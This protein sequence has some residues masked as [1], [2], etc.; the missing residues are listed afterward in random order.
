MT[1]LR[2]GDQLIRFDR[3]TTISAYSQIQQGGADRC[4]CSGCRNFALQRNSIYSIDF[5]DLLNTLGIDWTK[6]GEAVH[7]GPKGDLHFYGGWLYFV[8]EV[9]EAGER[10]VSLQDGFQYFIGTSFPRPHDVFGRPVAAVEFMVML[11][12]VLNEPYDPAF[13]TAI[14]K[15]QEIMERYPDALRK[16]ANSDRSTPK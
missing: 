12:W 7:Y 16:L 1:E 9:V 13:D 3:E 15:S 11:P 14:V 6:E 8:G 2:I 4:D 10:L 5:R